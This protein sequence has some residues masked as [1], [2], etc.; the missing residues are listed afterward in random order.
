MSER[1]EWLR[2]YNTYYKNENV[3]LFTNIFVENNTEPN[4][5]MQAAIAVLSTGPVGPSDKIGLSNVTIINA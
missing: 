4:P 2:P 1:E 5:E 3:Q